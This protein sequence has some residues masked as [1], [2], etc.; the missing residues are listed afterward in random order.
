MDKKK[1]N[2]ALLRRHVSYRIL[3]NKLDSEICEL[4]INNIM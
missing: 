4:I 3:C 2:A 1:I